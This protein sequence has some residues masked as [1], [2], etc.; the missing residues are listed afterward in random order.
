[1]F[2]ANQFWQYSLAFYASPRVK[3]VCLELQDRY[4]F[5]VNMLLL[6]GYLEQKSLRLSRADLRILLKNIAQI[7]Q[8]TRLIRKK[9][10]I[11]KKAEPA[12]YQQLL[13]EELALE[14]QQQQQLIKSLATICFVTQDNANLLVYRCNMPNS[15]EQ[16]MVDLM[17]ELGHLAVQFDMENNDR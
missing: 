11:A 14:K 12:H 10:V 13:R 17:T 1:M 8:Q 7:D 16:Q 6:C 9:R 5:N 4:G 3:D 2:S 15:Q